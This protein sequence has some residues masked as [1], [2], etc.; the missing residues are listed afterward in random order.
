MSSPT[1]P[2]SPVTRFMELYPRLRSTS[3]L[4]S[5]ELDLSTCSSP[6]PQPPNSD[7][8]FKNTQRD[9]ALFPA[10]TD[11]LYG[12]DTRPQPS[13]SSYAL[14]PQPHFVPQV[15]V[16]RRNWMPPEELA[17][18]RLHQ[19]AIHQAMV[20]RLMDRSPQPSSVTS[21]TTSASPTSAERAAVSDVPVKLPRAVTPSQC[22]GVSLSDSTGGVTAVQTQCAPKCLVSPN[23]QSKYTAQQTYPAPQTTRQRTNFLVPGQ[24]LTMGC[25]GFSDLDK[26][27]IN[28]RVTMCWSTI[29]ASEA[30]HNKKQQAIEYL[31][32]VTNHVRT[33]HSNWMMRDGIRNLWGCFKTIQELPP[34]D[35]RHMKAKEYMTTFGQ[36]LN[37]GATDRVEQALHAMDQAER[38]GREPLDEVEKYTSFTSAA[39]LPPRLEMPSPGRYPSFSSSIPFSAVP[40]G[41]LPAVRPL[42]QYHPLVSPGQHP[43]AIPSTGYTATAPPGQYSAV[44]PACMMGDESMRD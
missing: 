17:Y 31:T 26:K 21:D 44:D 43:A 2:D 41:Q 8:E 18:L 29:K 34:Q 6:T 37:A 14:Q 38:E 25:R 12:P 22:T 40:C 1:L 33:Q 15:S 32:N 23:P 39:A 3:P 35:P 27:N 36:K 28:T 9:C 7:E 30:P 5:G 42:G 11:Y 24:I 20:T 16:Y 10:L 4:T 13:P 19:R